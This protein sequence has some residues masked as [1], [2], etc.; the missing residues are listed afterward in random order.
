MFQGGPTQEDSMDSYIKAPTQAHREK[1]K[2]IGHSVQESMDSTLRGL[3][4]LKD[5]GPDT[6]SRRS[7]S[8]GSFH[9]RERSSSWPPGS[10]LLGADMEAPETDVLAQK[11]DSGLVELP[12]LF[13][14]ATEPQ[15]ASQDRSVGD[16]QKK[17][18]ATD[19][20]DSSGMLLESGSKDFSSLLDVGFQ[21]SSS[22]MI[23]PQWKSPVSEGKR[24]NFFASGPNT[25]IGSPTS[26]SMRVNIEGEDGGKRNVKGTG[27]GTDQKHNR[28]QS[29]LLRE[30]LREEFV[31]STFASPTITPKEILE[32]KAWAL[33]SQVQPTKPRIKIKMEGTEPVPPLSPGGGRPPLSPSRPQGQHRR[34]NPIQQQQMLA[35]ERQLQLEQAR[36]MNERAKLHAQQAA[37]AQ[38]QQMFARNA[39]QRDAGS[40]QRKLPQPSQQPR[41]QIRQ[42]QRGESGAMM[43]GNSQSYAA[44]QQSAAGAFQQQQHHQRFPVSP[45]AQGQTPLRNQSFS[46]ESSAMSS[47]SFAQQAMANRG[48]APGFGLPNP[49]G[50]NPSALSPTWAGHGSTNSNPGMSTR[51][52]DDSLSPRT[53]KKQREKERRQIL[54]AHYN[55]LLGLLKPRPNTRRMEKTTILEET[56]AM[57]KNLM[58]TNAALQARNK[59]LEMQ[60]RGMR[61]GKLLEKKI[62]PQQAA[63]RMQGANP[64]AGVPVT[65]SVTPAAVNVNQP[66]I[67][68]DARMGTES[69]S[70]D[71]RQRMENVM[72]GADLPL[73]KNTAALFN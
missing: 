12:P 33:N 23:D 25:P 20:P 62:Q 18:S 27:T 45:P 54:N 8:R 36:L 7:R 73:A 55:T 9:S 43:P 41:L 24:D 66:R 16:E 1:A 40:S 50:N 67:S 70:E 52:E 34:G 63:M 17:S 11:D 68:R 61:D 28:R 10:L 53:R 44:M 3:P 56:I 51:M 48:G 42:P 69:P 64:A 26:G 4:G 5:S 29:S 35:H 14:N 13:A 2:K 30:Q 22:I 6:Q 38:Q 37:L 19:G 60:L 15:P 72:V 32:K 46:R 57:I 65:V 49:L 21:P 59:E 39:M 58:D 31:N 71:L 47:N